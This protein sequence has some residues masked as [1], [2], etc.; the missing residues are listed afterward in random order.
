M[1]NKAYFVEHRLFT[2]WNNL[3]NWFKRPVDVVSR[4][5]DQSEKETDLLMKINNAVKCICQSLWKST[6]SNTWRGEI[7]SDLRTLKKCMKTWDHDWQ[8]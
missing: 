4:A 3:Q 2:E 7:P 8:P 6:S 5:T 1:E